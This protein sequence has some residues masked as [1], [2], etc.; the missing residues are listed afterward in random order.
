MGKEGKP[1]WPHGVAALQGDSLHHPLPQPFG[2]G[3][4][5]CGTSAGWPDPSV[6]LNFAISQPHSALLQ[7][8]CCSWMKAPPPQP[9]PND[10]SYPTLWSEWGTQW[11]LSFLFTWFLGQT[12]IFWKLFPDDGLGA[13]SV[14]SRPSSRGLGLGTFVSQ[15]TPQKTSEWDLFFPSPLLLNGWLNFLL[16]LDSFNL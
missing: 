16:W 5:C 6:Q 14:S 12:L 11:P 9:A 10:G 8:V 1:S 3:W 2:E 4:G 15:P 13:I 7:A